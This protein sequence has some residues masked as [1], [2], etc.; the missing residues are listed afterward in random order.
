MECLCLP[1]VDI[2]CEASFRE[3]LDQRIANEALRGRD[4]LGD[5]R[6]AIRFRL[7]GSSPDALSTMRNPFGSALMLPVRWYDSTLW[8][9]LSIIDRRTRAPLFAAWIEA[10][11]VFVS[12]PEP[13]RRMAG[14]RGSGNQRKLLAIDP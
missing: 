12:A 14:R 6:H 5:L 13:S 9:L 4:R 2:R 3:L 1:V 8:A 11:T 10:P 7:D